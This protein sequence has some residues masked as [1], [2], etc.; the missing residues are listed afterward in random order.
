MIT[1]T[2]WRIIEKLSKGD[3]T[4]TELAKE[5][6]ISIPSVH[7]QLVEL[8]RKGLIKKIDVVKGKTRPYQ[9]Y[10]LGDGFIFFIKALPHETERKFVEVD[11][12]IKMHLRIWSIP[13][14]E[15]HYPVEVYLWSLKP[16]LR[17]IDAIGIF[18]SVARGNATKESD[19]DIL[20]ISCKKLEISSRMAEGRMFMPQVFSA[21]DFKNS[22]RRGSKFIAEALKNIVILYDKKG[23]LKDAERATG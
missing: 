5:M 11:D 18:G 9:Q 16:K 19:V 10:S 7:K 23:V 17:D 14:K 4:P 8:E 15:F 2:R 22:I 1:E 21:G 12:N 13:Q 6:G 20:I 3:K